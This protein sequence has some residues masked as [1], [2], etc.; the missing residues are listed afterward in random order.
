MSVMVAGYIDRA[1][2]NYLAVLEIC[3]CTAAIAVKYG[4]QK[5]TSFNRTYSYTITPYNILRRENAIEN[6]IG[7]I[8]VVQCYVKQ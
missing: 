2:S 3:T 6:F 8:L 4:V 5:R 1:V 7:S